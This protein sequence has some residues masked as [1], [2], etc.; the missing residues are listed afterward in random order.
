MK[1][2]DLD[3]QE[4]GDD[5]AYLRHADKQT[6]AA[7]RTWRE[8]VAGLSEEKRREY[9]GL[10]LIEPAGKKPAKAKTWKRAAACEERSCFKELEAEKEERPDEVL[11]QKETAQT[12]APLVATRFILAA[13]IDAHGP[14]LEASIVAIALGIGQLQGITAE[15]LARVCLLS[16]QTVRRRVRAWKAR[17]E[18]GVDLTLPKYVV[19]HVLDDLRPRLQADCFALAFDFP[20]RQGMSERQLAERY[21]LTVATLSARVLWWVDEMNARLP[22]VCKKRTSAYRDSNVR[23]QPDNPF[24]KP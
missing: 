13:I 2:T 3:E 22:G 18:A 6:A 10:K 4:A 19:S 24:R 5:R 17:F 15:S 11:I 14:R 20:L 9:E 23:R 8:H 12:I 7:D 1:P 16:E 21:G